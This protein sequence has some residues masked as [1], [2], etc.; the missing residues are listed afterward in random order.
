MG[1]MGHLSVSERGGK[2]LMS[3]TVYL[4]KMAW[5]AKLAFLYPYP[6]GSLLWKGI[7]AGLL[8][9]AI[10]VGVVAQVSNLLYRRFPIGRPSE[11]P[12][13]VIDTPVSQAGSTALRQVGNLR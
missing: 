12:A 8:L 9:L 4:W 2:P 6:E 1:G 13:T 11:R 10:T 7:G 3:Y 5:P